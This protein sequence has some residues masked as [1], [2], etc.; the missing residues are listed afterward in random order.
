M[1]RHIL[2]L[3]A[4]AVL[5]GLTQTALTAE[6]ENLAP[7]ATATSPDGL[8]ADGASSGPQAAIDGNPET[9][10]D[11]TDNQP[12]YR[13]KLDF[14]SPTDVAALR[15]LGY[16]HHNFAPKDFEILCDGQVVK[17]VEAAA[18]RDNWLLIKLPKTTCR[19]L[20]LKITGS[21]GSSP[22]IR[23]LE[24][25]A[26][27]EGLPVRAIESPSPKGPGYQ[28][29]RTDD[30]LALF[31]DGKVVWRSDHQAGLGKPCLHP[32]GLVD[33]TPLTWFRPADH[34]WHRGVWLTWKYINGLCYWEEGADGLSPGRTDV[35]R[36]KAA[37]R[38]DASARIELDV[39]FHPPEQPPVMIE[40]R[41]INFSR[42]ESDGT[43][44]IDW[45]STFVALDD[46]VLERT[47]ILGEPDGVAHGGYAG[48]SIRM[49]A[50][51][52]GWNVQT[53]EG[54]TDQDAH[55]KPARWLAAGGKTPDGKPAGIAI[56]DHP[57]N[58]RHPSP[59]FVAK[60][61]PYY[62]PAVVFNEPL[63]LAAGESLTLR[64]RVLIYTGQRNKAAL[65]KEW[66][67]FRDS[68]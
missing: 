25:F 16:L 30:S 15:I 54:A 49:A 19:S 12:E 11:E 23:E 9:Y 66:D 38:E 56:F 46:L 37:A 68:D 51:T 44:R 10:W 1:T 41:I 18:Y 22:A 24:I 17:K 47:P 48:F 53:S 5:L 8:V 20:E 55:G 39:S 33:G 6:P 64:Y 65:D 27:T 21:H 29:Q 31:N 35:L 52:R 45:Q 63:K 14:P 2:Y 42:P 3:S 62:S 40:Q 32:V 28:W 7:K 4:L 61:M 58:A 60:D 50:E 57:Q 34:P 67:E 36:V 13:L 43:Y 26:T 59:W